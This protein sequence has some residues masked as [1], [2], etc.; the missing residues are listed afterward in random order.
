VKGK[1]EARIKGLVWLA[2]AYSIAFLIGSLYYLRGFQAALISIVV[3]LVL[4]GG[5]NF[6]RKQGYFVSRQKTPISTE[7]EEARLGLEELSTLLPEEFV[8]FLGEFSEL[9][10]RDVLK[11]V[12]AFLERA[13]YLRMVLSVAL[14]RA[15]PHQVVLCRLKSGEFKGDWGFPAGYVSPRDKYRYA[16]PRSKADYEIRKYLGIDPNQLTYLGCLTEDRPL[17]LS[18][19]NPADPEV[20]VYEYALRDSSDVRLRQVE[21]IRVV[22]Y[23]EIEKLEGQVNP[24]VYDILRHYEQVVFSKD[25]ED[26]MRVAKERKLLVFPGG[27]YTFF[28]NY[29]K[30]R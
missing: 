11:E 22:T 5:F 2:L 1:M 18:Y 19:S 13:E 28:E 15:G 7:A 9:E 25:F 12:M 29:K 17:V 27:A 30:S 16:D 4:V 14:V 20:V 10:R 24:L 3:L 21:D 6:A 26:K 8:A 23:A